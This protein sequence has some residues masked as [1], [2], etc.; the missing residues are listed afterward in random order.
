MHEMGIAM[1][2][3]EIATAA[4]P[5]TMKDAKVEKV[6]LRIGKLSAIVPSSLNFC[7]QAVAKDT[8]LENATLH[9]EDVPITMRCQ[10]CRH[11]W[12]CE[13]LA[14]TCDACQKGPVDIIT[15]REL[16]VVSIEIEEMDSSENEG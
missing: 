1:K 13:E 4:L 10:T 12:N 14:F 5:E 15:G 2:I 3:A 7:F 8:P 9:I 11:E 16:D 6:N